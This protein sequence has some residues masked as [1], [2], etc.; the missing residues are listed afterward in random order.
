MYW[1]LTGTILFIRA[2]LFIGMM[3]IFC[4]GQTE[5]IPMYLNMSTV[6]TLSPFTVDMLAVAKTPPSSPPT[7]T[8]K[9]DATKVANFVKNRYFRFANRWVYENFEKSTF[10]PTSELPIPA[11]Q[12]LKMKFRLPKITILK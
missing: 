3:E 8:Y 9:S 6:A 2:L 1:V 5:G 4:I 11:F 12:S 7:S 10:S